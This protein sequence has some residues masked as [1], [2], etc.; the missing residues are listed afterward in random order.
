MFRPESPLAD[1]RSLLPRRL[2]PVKAQIAPA[3]KRKNRRSLELN[4]PNDHA[5]YDYPKLLISKTTESLNS[6]CPRKLIN[7][8][9]S[10]DSLKRALLSKDEKKED[11]KAQISKQDSSESLK[12]LLCRQE[13]NESAKR[14]DSDPKRVQNQDVK[15][16]AEVKRGSDKKGLLET[17]C[18]EPIKRIYE[19]RTGCARPTLPPVAEK[20][21][22]SPSSP[23][24]SPSAPS[25]AAVAE[26]L[27]RWG[28][29]LLSPKDEPR[30]R[31]ARSWYGYGT[32]PTDSEKV[33]GGTGPGGRRALELILSGGLKSLTRPAKPV[34]R[35]ASRDSVLAQPQP[36]LEG[37][38]KCSTVLALT[39]R[40]KAPEPIRAHN[41]LRAPSVCS[42]CSSLLSLAGGGSRYSLDGAGGGFVPAAPINCKLCLEDATADKVTVISGCG[43]QF[44][45]KCMAAYVEFEVCNGAYEVSC[46]DARCR[47][48]AALSLD[49]ISALLEPSVMEKHKKF[50]LNHEVA[51]DSGR[52]FCPRVG[53]DTVVTV[54]AASPAHCPTCRHDFCSQC[55]Q[56]WHGGLTCE[57]AAASSSSGLG[58]PLLPSSE[59]IKLCPMCRVPIEKDEGCAQM[60]CK[61]CKHVF[62]W[63]CL[64]SLDD[65]FL[66]R[67]YDKGPCKN[68]LGHSRASVLWHRAQVVG[69]FAGF[70]L[71]LLVASPLL[72]LA[73]PCIVCCKC[74]LC[75]PSTKN[76]EEVDEIDS[77]SPRDEE[78]VRARY[79]AD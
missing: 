20:G 22:V 50:R 15:R 12:K 30:L 44:C 24:G 46:P 19:R 58:A 21:A 53:C 66:L 40:E 27:V 7:K 47:V 70:G 62:C 52:A 34:R 75:N 68:K 43:C 61:R 59:L 4:P 69:I 51:M 17:D 60:M 6:E 18:D 64:A 13:S 73:A 14:R 28:S 5:A 71:L 37:L 8:Q 77:I 56:E 9:D 23:N 65:D 32:L 11:K 76:L 57:A 49:E 41:R 33:G 54:N 16:V 74:R 67:H 42:R 38:R 10:S 72:L 31:A 79:L 48:G 1:H 26:G 55:N 45:T 3:D 36:L 35:A 2:L 39:D 63:Y 25:V 29:G 78:D